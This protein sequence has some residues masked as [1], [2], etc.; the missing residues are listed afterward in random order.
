MGADD[1]IARAVARRRAAA[2]AARRADGRPQ[3]PSSGRPA[4]PVERRR[5]APQRDHRRR[6]A[7]RFV[8]AGVVERLDPLPLRRAALDQREGTLARPLRAHRAADRDRR[9]DLQAAMARRE[10]PGQL[11][12]DDPRGGARPLRRAAAARVTRRWGAD[13]PVF[14][15]RIK[16]GIRPNAF[17]SHI[18]R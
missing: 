13:R 15:G 9:R 2:D 11:P 1:H 14:V 16:I 4:D 5:A 10:A 17:S 18:G 7:D 3:P 8:G 12:R 6:T